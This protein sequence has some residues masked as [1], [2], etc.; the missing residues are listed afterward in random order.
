MTEKT[1]GLSGRRSNA[2]KE[3]TANA[4]IQIRV[5]PELKAHYVALA[6]EA[7]LSLSSWILLAAEEKAAQK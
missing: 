7:G 5:M 6:E 2:A 1:H 4:T 3:K